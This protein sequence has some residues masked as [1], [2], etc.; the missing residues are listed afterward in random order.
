MDDL[1]A[2]LDQHGLEEHIDLF[3][4]QQV[5]VSDLMMFTEDDVFELG[6]PLG[7]RKRLLAAIEALRSEERT[8]QA[9]TPSEDAP[10]GG[11]ERRQLTVMFCDL[12]GSTALSEQM[13]PEEYREILSRYQTAA[14]EVIGR[15]EG[16]IARYMGD[17][18]L[19]YFGYP[20]AHEDDA[21]RAIRA[22]LGVVEAIAALTVR[23]GIELSVRIGLDTGPVVVGDIIGEGA[24]EESAVLGETPNRAA[25]LQAVAAPNS[26]VQV[27]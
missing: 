23:P 13:D 12:V 27:W 24:S 5:R 17:G 9:D 21:A 14:R 6:L 18:L 20:L 2:W 3:R 22:G 25:R 4:E 8:A 15:H 7:P 16:Y 10:T 11:A 26:V 19:I 1:K